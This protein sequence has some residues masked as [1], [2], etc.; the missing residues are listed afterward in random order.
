MRIKFLKEF[1]ARTADGGRRLIE[2]ETVLE[3][4]DE[5]GSRLVAA[6]IAM[7]LDALAEAWKAYYVSADQI[8]RSSGIPGKSWRRH[9]E[10][11]NAAKKLSQSGDLPAIRAELD[12]A[13]AVLC[14][15]PISGDS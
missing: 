8:Y 14:Y 6:G 2:P 10:H 11:L 12:K 9:M 1:A 15:G 3:L 4:T 7:D 5:K 13:L